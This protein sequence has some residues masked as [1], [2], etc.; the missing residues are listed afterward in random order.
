[1]RSKHVVVM[2][3]ALLTALVMAVPAMGQSKESVRYKGR[4]AEAGF[5]SVQG[6]V[7]TEVFVTAQDPKKRRG[8][9]NTP[10]EASVSIF[11]FD[12]C[13]PE[14]GPEGPGSESLL[15]AAFGMTTLGANDFVVDKDL[16]TAA[17]DTSVRMQDQVSGNSFIVNVDLSWRATAAP[18]PFKERYSYET[19]GFSFSGRVKGVARTAIASGSVA[20][21]NVLYATGTSDFARLLSI[22]SRTKQ[23]G[24]PP[25]DAGFPGGGGS[26]EPAAL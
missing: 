16:G 3:L 6:C 23:S 19:T 22:N 13:A 12:A 20:G 11:R 26:P 14:P 25:E 21:G 15:T 24:Q 8:S 2:V 7:G 10:S 5:S 17:L 4:L 18:R 1:M 9:Q